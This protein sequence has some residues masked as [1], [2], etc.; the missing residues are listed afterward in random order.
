MPEPTTRDRLAFAG[1][2]FVFASGWS[3][4]LAMFYF[5]NVEHSERGL[6]AIVT[7]FV[8]Q[9]AMVLL[10]AATMRVAPWSLDRATK[11]GQL[12]VL[13]SLASVVAVLSAA[14][15]FLIA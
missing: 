1:W 11:L 15:T 5:N 7:W 13:L 12:G 6:G 3:L 9:P 4:L 8:S 10:S 2:V 14:L